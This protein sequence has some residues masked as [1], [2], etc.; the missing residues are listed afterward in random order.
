MSWWGEFSIW[1]GV[2]LLAAFAWI[3]VAC[4]FRWF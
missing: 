3:G 1:I 2:G 4:Y